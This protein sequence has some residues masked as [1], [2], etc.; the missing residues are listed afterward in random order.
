MT[1]VA[2]PTPFADLNEV[3]A[4]L[5][6]RVRAVL[7]ENLIGVYLVGSFAGG[8]ADEYSDVDYLVVIRRDIDPADIEPLQAMHRDLYGLPSQWA[9]HLEGSYAPAGIWRRKPGPGRPPG[10]DRPADWIDPGNQRPLGNYPLLYLDNGAQTLVRSTHDNELVVRWLMR[11]H[12][13]AMAGPAAA[14]LIDPIDDDDL[15]AEVL[16]T[17]RDW[18]GKIL[19][20]PGIVNSVWYQAFVVMSYC[21]M[22]QTVATAAVQSKR[23]GI[24]WGRANLDARWQGLIDRAWAERP[25]PWS[26]VHTPPDPDELAATLEFVEYALNRTAPNGGRD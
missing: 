16:G 15:R 9:Q 12:G 17:M 21:R 11:H 8:D 14:S 6:E 24:E 7:G 13:I 10:D 4:T 25:N 2:R 22:L 5:V 1:S 20:N 3:L 18:G 19:A 26:K 23:A